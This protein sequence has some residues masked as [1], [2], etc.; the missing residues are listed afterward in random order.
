MYYAHISKINN[1]TT[2]TITTTTLTAQKK[3]TCLIN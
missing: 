1:T 3:W 2:T